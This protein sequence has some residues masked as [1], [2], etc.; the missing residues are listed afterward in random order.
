MENQQLIIKILEY[1]AKLDVI[2]SLLDNMPIDRA[3]HLSKL[4]VHID[5]DE[6][7]KQL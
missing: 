5:L 3:K 1:K 6:L 7:E 2:T 4:V